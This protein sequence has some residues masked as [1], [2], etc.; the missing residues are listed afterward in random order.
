LPS[1]DNNYIVIGTFQPN[2]TMVFIFLLNAIQIKGLQKIF[3][4]STSA[5]DSSEFELNEELELEHTLG[6]SNDS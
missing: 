1:N 4:C 6:Q 5:S 2:S 3:T